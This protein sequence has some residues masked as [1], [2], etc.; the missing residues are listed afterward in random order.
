METFHNRLQRVPS[1]D[2]AKALVLLDPG[3]APTQMARAL[4]ICSS[5]LGVG[6]LG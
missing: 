5:C 1:P 4:F 6:V 2:L 3:Q